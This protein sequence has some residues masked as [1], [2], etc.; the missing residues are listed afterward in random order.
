MRTY[1]VA[2]GSRD[3][4]SHACKRARVKNHKV[5]DNQGGSQPAPG[6]GTMC[7]DPVL[8]RMCGG[9]PD[10]DVP[11][12]LNFGQMTSVML[13]RPCLTKMQDLSTTMKEQLHV[14]CHHGLYMLLPGLPH[15]QSQSGVHGRHRCVMLRPAA[16]HCTGSWGALCC[17]P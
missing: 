10:G 15:V 11:A 4:S 17:K 1:G 16:A 13:V 6:P 3:S 7:M 2:S 12:V 9:R 14:H 8:T 5:L